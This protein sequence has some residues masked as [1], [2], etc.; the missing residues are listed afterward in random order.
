MTSTYDSHMATRDSSAQE[1]PAGV[2]DA[3]AETPSAAEPATPGAEASPPPQTLETAAT[4]APSMIPP[5]TPPGRPPGAAPRGDRVGPR[6]LRR[7]TVALLVL[8]PLLGALL[9][10]GGTAIYLSAQSPSYTAHALVSVLPADA[11]AEVSTAFTDIWVQI[12]ASDPVVEAAAR[13]IDTTPGILRDRLQVTQAG[14][15]ALVSISVTTPDAERSADWANEVADE[16]IAQATPTTVPGYTLSQVTTA[17][18][19]PASTG[20]STPLLVLGAAV[21]GLIAGAALG[22]ALGRRSR[23]RARATAR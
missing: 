14:S 16:L 17:V 23:R 15:A 11:T 18:P 10:G 4:A 22:Q 1:A 7:R 9:L 5:S 3:R 21:A 13:R 6:R 20:P 8:L 2:D 19:P 12:G